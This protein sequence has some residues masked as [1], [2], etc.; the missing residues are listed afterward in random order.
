MQ[1]QQTEKTTQ[2]RKVYATPALVQHGS[3]T[4]NTLGLLDGT[5]VEGGSF[6][7]GYFI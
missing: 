3:V 1:T 2:S 6:H 5:K 7:S 4:A